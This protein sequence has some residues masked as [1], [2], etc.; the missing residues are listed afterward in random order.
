VKLF[1]RGD[2]LH[3]EYAARNAALAARGV[4]QTRANTISPRLVQAGQVFYWKIDPQPTAGL[5]HRRRG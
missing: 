4:P 3:A 2:Y 1:R 5:G